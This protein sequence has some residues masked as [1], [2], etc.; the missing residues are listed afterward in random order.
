MYNYSCQ[1]SEVSIWNKVLHSTFQVTVSNLKPDT[2]YN[3]SIAA[4]TKVGCGV[5]SS[6]SNK[7]SEG[8][9]SNVV[10]TSFKLN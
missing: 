3:C 1:D 6:V 4:C 9:K 5:R 10:L 2:T 8:S 7:T